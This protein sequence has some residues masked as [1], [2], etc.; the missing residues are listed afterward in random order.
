[1]EKLIF[2]LHC[3]F[4]KFEAIDKEELNDLLKV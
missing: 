4:K 2:I 1:M 3:G